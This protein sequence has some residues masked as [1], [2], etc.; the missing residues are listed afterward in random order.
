[1]KDMPARGVREIMRDEFEMRSKITEV[2]LSGPRSI[3]EI[4]DALG[5]PKSEVVR[6]VMAMWKYGAVEE[7][8]KPDRSGYYRYRMKK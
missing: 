5:C 8:G 7:D 1:M 6:W 2:L 4:A 3:P